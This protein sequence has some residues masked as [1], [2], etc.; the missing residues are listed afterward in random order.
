MKLLPH[1][2]PFL[3]VDRVEEIDPKREYIRAIKNVSHNEPYFQ[4]HFPENPIMPGVLI[5]ETM[6]QVGGIYIKTVFPEA[7][8]KLF[9]FAAIDKARFRRPVFPGDTL[10]IEAQGFKRKGHIIKTTAK[11]LVQGRLVAE[12]EITAAI[13]EPGELHA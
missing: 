6:A 13:I 5:I 11:A 10:T 7:Q 9:V 4:G 1:R 8:D 12:A 3:M 2:Y